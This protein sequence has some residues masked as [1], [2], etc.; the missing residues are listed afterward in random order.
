M[1]TAAA[2]LS[3]QTVQ[4]I[5]I[6]S[7]RTDDNVRRRLDNLESLAE[8]ITLHGVLTAITVTRA[9]DGAYNL[10]AGFR[11]VAAA[12]MAGLATIPAVVRDP[13]D[14]AARLQLQ[15]AE[16][17]ERDALGDLDQAGAPL[18]HFRV[19]SGG[20]NAPGYALLRGSSLRAWA[21][22]ADDSRIYGIILHTRMLPEMR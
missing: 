10:L 18:T 15:L 21:R 13:T 19:H 14:P 4:I 2:D 22:S 3:A 11:R 9:D 6:A 16:N 7:I 12:T 5:P 8:S 17:L 20:E 1:A